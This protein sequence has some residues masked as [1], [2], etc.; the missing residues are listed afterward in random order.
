M[1][2]Y[3]ITY[4]V[5]QD[6][7]FKIWRSYNNRYWPAEYFIDKNGKVRRTHFGEGEYDESG[8]VHPGTSGRNR[9]R[10]DTDLL[11][12]PANLPG[13]AR[14]PETYLGYARMERFDSPEKILPDANRIYSF[15]A[16]WDGKVISSSAYNIS[17]CFRAARR[18]DVTPEHARS[19][20]GA[21]LAFALPGCPGVSRDAQ[22][23]GDERAGIL[24][25]SPDSSRTFRKRCP[26]RHGHG[27]CRPAVSPRKT[28]RAGRTSPDAGISRCGN[29]D[30]R[31]YL[32]LSSIKRSSFMRFRSIFCFMALS[33]ESSSGLRPR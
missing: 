14:T 6:N 30:L 20:V 23:R 22:R 4:P 10:I 9:R 5:V 26:K 31:L 15:P 7:D 24:G 1:A 11:D 28:P 2:D 27:R 18:M 17:R 12:L 19:T 33:S 8:T 13:Y 21:K 16:L 32:R 3:G 25:W 29:G